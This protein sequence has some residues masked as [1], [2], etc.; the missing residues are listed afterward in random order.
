MN[1]DCIPNGII[2][3][4]PSKLRLTEVV[5]LWEHWRS[6]QKDGLIGLEF[7]KEKKGDMRENDKKGKKRADIPW[8][9]PDEEHDEDLH[10]SPPDVPSQSSRRGQPQPVAGPSGSHHQENGAPSGQEDRDIDEDLHVQSPAAHKSTKKGRMA[11]L[12]TLSTKSEY[13]AMLKDIARLKVCILC[14]QIAVLVLNAHTGKQCWGTNRL[15]P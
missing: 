6:R 7:V 15:V 13:L 11:F 12:K 9:N 3:R 8:V 14:D 1:L 10:R 4:E 2:L 5:S